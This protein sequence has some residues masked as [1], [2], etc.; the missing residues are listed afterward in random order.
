MA[1]TLYL[2]NVAVKQNLVRIYLGAGAGGVAGAGAAASR[3]GP[4]TI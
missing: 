4:A 1:C 3:R 2:Y